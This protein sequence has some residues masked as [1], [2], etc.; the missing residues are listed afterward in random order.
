MIRAD[1]QQ[2]M[3]SALW[4]KMNT[5]T[6]HY[7]LIYALRSSIGNMTLSCGV[8]FSVTSLIENFH[9]NSMHCWSWRYC[10]SKGSV[11]T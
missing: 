3:A 10:P 9:T 2:G 6:E 7:R 4:F 5:V 1:F 8:L 11:F